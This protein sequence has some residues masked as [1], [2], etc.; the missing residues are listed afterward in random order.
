MD[1][2]FDTLDG[3]PGFIGEPSFAKH[4]ANLGALLI[5]TYLGLMLYGLS[6]HQAYGFYTPS[7]KE[8]SRILKTAVAIILHDGHYRVCGDRKTDQKAKSVVTCLML[9]RPFPLGRKCKDPDGFSMLIPLQKRQSSWRRFRCENALY[10]SNPFLL[11][12]SRK[13]TLPLLMLSRYAK[14]HPVRRVLHQQ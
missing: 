3:L 6:L 4:G 13:I 10:Y 14:R 12:K 2:R 5:G 9:S 7:H 8:T 1:T 11:P